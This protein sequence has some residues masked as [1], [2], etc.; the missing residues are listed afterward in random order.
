MTFTVST[1]RGSSAAR[2]PKR[3]SASASVLISSSA[4]T[5]H[6]SRRNGCAPRTMPRSSARASPGTSRR[7]AHVIAGH[8]DLAREPRVGDIDPVLDLLVP[9]IRGVA[10]EVR[11]AVDVAGLREIGGGQ[12]RGDL[13]GQRER[14]VAGILLPAVL[15]GPRTVADDEARRAR[16]HRPERRQHRPGDRALAPGHV[17]QQHRERAFVELDAVPVGRAVQPAVLRP[18]AVV[19]LHRTQVAHHAQHLVVCAAGEEGA[20]GLRQVARPDQMVAA[21]VVVALAAA[22]GDRQAGD[23]AA[24]ERRAFVAAQHR[25]ADA[26]DVVPVH[27]AVQRAQAAPASARQPVAY[28]SIWRSYGVCRLARTRNAASARAAAEAQREAE[29]GR[30]AM[31]SRRSARHCRRRR[32]RI[33]RSAGR[34]RCSIC[35]PSEA[36]TKPDR[37]RPGTAASSRA[38]GTCRRPR[39]TAGDGP[40]SRRSRRCCAPRH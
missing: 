29:L 38:R 9:G 16:D 33:R 11:D 20:R 35:Q 34:C 28:S 13:H 1:M 39:R 23:Q 14:R 4:S 19:L 15:A 37:A 17:Q 8:A 36:P 3:T 12:Q 18:A 21:Q 40:C 10:Q 32:G 31:R 5:W 27:L 6:A 26:V 22:P 24:R 2:S 30:R 7:D 25:G